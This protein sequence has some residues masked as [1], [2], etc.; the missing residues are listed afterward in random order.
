MIALLSYVNVSR[1]THWSLIRLVR[2]I[3]I[4]LIPRLNLLS[5]NRI[6]FLVIVPIFNC[7]NSSHRHPS[8]A[9]ISLYNVALPIYLPIYRYS[10]ES[11]KIAKLAI[12]T[13]I[14]IRGMPRWMET[15][16]AGRE[17]EYIYAASFRGRHHGLNGAAVT[18]VI[19]ENSTTS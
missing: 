19:L 13:K 7:Q 15:D 5:S 18:T 9:P 2:V 8:H 16:D 10:H 1:N 12:C 11:F 3:S 6:S 14:N 17:I 4:S